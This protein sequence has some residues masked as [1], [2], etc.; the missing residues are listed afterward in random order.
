VESYITA[1]EAGKQWGRHPG[2][3]LRLGR[4]GLLRR[5]K[6]RP[7]LFDAG[8]VEAFMAELDADDLKKVLEKARPVTRPGTPVGG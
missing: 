2:F 1:E 4:V 8:E 3:F 6:L 7:V 5:K